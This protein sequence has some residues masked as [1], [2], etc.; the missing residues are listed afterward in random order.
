MSELERQCEAPLT[1]DWQSGAEE[2]GKHPSTGS[3][4]DNRIVSCNVLWYGH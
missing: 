3:H 4:K 1:T 2:V